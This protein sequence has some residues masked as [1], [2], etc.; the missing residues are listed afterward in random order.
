[1]SVRQKIRQVALYSVAAAVTMVF[2]PASV[3]QFPNPGGVYIDADGV[4]RTREVKSEGTGRKGRGGQR[5]DAFHYVSLSRV[6]EQAKEHLQV[7]RELPEELRY[8]GGITKL[9]YIVAYPEEQDLVI[10]G[11]AEPFDA[12]QPGEGPAL[13]RVTGRPVLCLDDFVVCLRSERRGAFGCSIDL[14]RDV[15]QRVNAVASQI[16][17]V[18]SSAPLPRIQ[19]AFA[20]GVGPQSTRVFGVP[21]DNRVARACVEA[22]YIMKRL[23][24]GLQQSPVRGVKSQ[25]S[26]RRGDEPVF[27]RYWFTAFYEPLVVSEDGCQFEIRGQGL[28]VKASD[29]P[30]GDPSKAS[31]SARRFA[32]QM[33]EHFPE[34]TDHIAQFAELQNVMDLAVL[35]ALIRHDQLDQRCGLNWEWLLQPK[36]YPVPKAEFPTS[37]DTVAVAKMLRRKVDVMIGGV[38]LAPQAVVAANRESIAQISAAARR[39]GD[40]EW[41]LRTETPE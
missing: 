32:E 21:P 5:S 8:L 22:D 16:G 27:S 18:S 39:P 36:E 28:Q 15:A 7:G 29:L 19:N 6:V 10:A 12:P 24:L 37:V 1:M 4:L 31:P 3:A 13:G 35:A 23:A 30:T 2:S 40:G 26:Q 34:L 38:T 14:P 41:I 25:A 33:T 17:A 11:P 9:K 20:Q